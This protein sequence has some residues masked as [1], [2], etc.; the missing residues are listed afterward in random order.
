LDRVPGGAE[1]A[2]GGPRISEVE[3]PAGSERWTMSKLE[4]VN[5]MQAAAF[6]KD[7]KAFQSYCADD[8]YYRVGNVE[9]VT[10]PEAVAAYLKD[11]PSLGF[12]IT[13]MDVRGAWETDAVAVAEYT[14]QGLRHDSGNTVEYPCVDIY[15][16]E[17][18]KISD[19]R[20]NPME[21]TFVADPGVVGV[22]RPKVGSRQATGATPSL[23]GTVN[24]FQGALRGGDKELA[25]SLL[26]EDAVVRV[27]DRQEVR[28]PQA[29]L[30]HVQEIFTRR[31]KPTGA[32]L[33]DVWEFE[34]VLLEEL[35]VQATRAAD[36]RAVEY[37]CVESN[38]IERGKIREWRIYPI[39]PTLLAREG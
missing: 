35:T 15:R 10:G 26:A 9:E 14:M 31:L 32:D 39:E 3:G 30:D 20:V 25:L 36:G 12:T 5:A 23:L 11:L 27:A 18:E 16:F 19:W 24:A 37:P 21:P 38:R 17:G 8:I 13:R 1:G 22:R 2:E 33:V 7:W 34:G 4:V 6:A 28:G 29:I